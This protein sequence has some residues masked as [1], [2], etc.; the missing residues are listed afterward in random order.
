MHSC[1][2]SIYPPPPRHRLTAPRHCL[3]AFM[4]PDMVKDRST[5]N[6]YTFE[7]R[8]HAGPN[9]GPNTA[10]VVY[11]SPASGAVHRPETSDLA[12]AM[13]KKYGLFVR[14]QA[15]FSIPDTRML[16]FLKHSSVRTL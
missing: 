1:H 11:P 4:Y 5:I 9:A 6:T 15:T 13:L 10:V 3:A 12:F 8:V 16:E 2:D 14:P 7:T